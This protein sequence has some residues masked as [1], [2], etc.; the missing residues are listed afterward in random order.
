MESIIKEF[1]LSDMCEYSNFREPSK[2][3][4]EALKKRDEILKKLK[5]RL[6][7]EDFSLIDEYTEI[8]VIINEEDSYYAFMCGIRTAL[9]ILTEIFFSE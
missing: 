1:F 4:A 2:E 9:K 3:K 8:R 5:E 6:S 7:S